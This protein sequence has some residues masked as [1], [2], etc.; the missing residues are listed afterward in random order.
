MIQVKRCS[1]TEAK[2]SKLKDCLSKTLDKKFNV[3]VKRKK[4]I[5]QAKFTLMERLVTGLIPVG[6]CVIF[7]S[8]SIIFTYLFYFFS[9]LVR[10]LPVTLLLS[11]LSVHRVFCAYFVR[12]EGA[13]VMRR[14]LWC[15][16]HLFCTQLFTV[17]RL[18]KMEM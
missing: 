15:N 11:G 17:L 2:S 4:G 10:V 13:G 16:L 8:F 6:K 7:L 5:P 14:F 3:T 18:K 1:T 9:V 12:F